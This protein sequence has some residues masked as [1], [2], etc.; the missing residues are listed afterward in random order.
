MSATVSFHRLQTA[1]TRSAQNQPS[2]VVFRVASSTTPVVA[3]KAPVRCCSSVSG[4]REK[5]VSRS[6][7]SASVS[8]S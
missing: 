5:R 1:A 6:R 3:A 2:N 8:P 4:N 7:V